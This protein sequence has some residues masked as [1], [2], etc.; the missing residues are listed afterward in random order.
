MTRSL[1]R[2]DFARGIAATASLAAFAP[3]GLLRADTATKRVVIR[4]AD[5]IGTVR[6]ELHSHFAEHLG[7][8]IYGGLWV[9]PKSPIANV[10][11][12]RKQAVDYL[13]ELGIPAL[14]WPG[15]C[16]AD[17][18]HWR[19][20]I[21]PAAKRSKRV[22]I[23][24][25]GYIE[26]NSFGT[27]EFIG[28][29]K[30][31]GAQP[32]LAGNV[33]SGNPEEMR[34]WVEYCNQPSGSALSD[35][36][37]ANGSPEPFAVKY[38]GVGNE[39]WGCGGEMKPEEYATEYRRFA[40]YLR[41][42]GGTRPFLIASGPNGNDANWSHGVLGNLRGRIPDGFAMHYYE[43]GADYPTKFTAQHV[44]DQLAIFA[45][46]EQAIIQQRA[47]IDGY[48]NGTRVGLLL[49]EW[50]VWDQL[51]RDEEKR[52]GNLY[53]QSS[54]RSAVAAGL[55]LNM[56]NR[57]ADKLYMCNIAQIVNVLQSLLL[58]DGPEGKNCVRTSTYYAFQLFK[59]HRTQTA[60]KVESDD[61]GPLA[62]S[63]SASKGHYQMGEQ[64]GSD[65]TR[66]QIV[67]SFVNP[68][69]DSD[70]S[71]QCELRDASA[72]GA[73]GQILHDPDWNAANTF[74]N[75]DKLVPKTFD[76][77]ASGS[78]IRFDLPGMSVATV[79]VQTS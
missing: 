60:L 51:D 77:H 17:D 72:A 6:P 61:T 71:V 23:H 12:Y 20:G 25:G 28:L 63:A 76:V 27:H 54:M 78:Q 21:G 43:G 56:F 45:K 11:G 10:N 40:V 44:S 19:E 32:Y 22:N 55:G 16:F 59:P 3:S 50:G 36:R 52:M 58:T 18:Y 33:G 13:R 75:P 14:R 1:S 7:S 66:T 47:L 5:E 49:D 2:R 69:T 9:G 38:W 67:A 74:D 35:E 34:D 31:I 68:R 65:N 24:W 48:P 8:C 29:C 37:A 15:G 62:L 30:L 26:D 39:S 73:T 57:H 64:R 53:E 41:T 79:T 46:V 4:A 42:Y 70:I